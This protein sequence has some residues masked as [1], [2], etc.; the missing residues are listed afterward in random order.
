[1]NLTGQWA[2]VLALGNVCLAAG[3]FLLHSATKLAGDAHV[4]LALA[5]AIAM[6]YLYQGPPFRCTMVF[7]G[8]R[9]MMASGQYVLEIR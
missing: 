2:G 1:M 8:S 4:G 7:P 6:G 5:V 3:A 9:S